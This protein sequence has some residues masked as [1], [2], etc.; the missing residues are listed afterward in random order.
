VQS[1]PIELRGGINSYLYVGASPLSQF[2]PLG[3]VTTDGRIAPGTANTIIC[4]G[5]GNIISQVAPLD[6]VNQECLGD[7]ILQHEESHR[8]DA[9]RQNAQVC[10]G[11][12]RG[13]YVL[14][15]NTAEQKAGEIKAS[16]IEIMCLRN[17]ISPT[18]CNSCD[19]II[20]DRIKQMERYRD[21]F[22]K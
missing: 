10:I 21:R 20:L 14:F 17:K 22:R 19:E 1:D 4:N 11:K 5:N 2:D 16:E 15:S 8:Q 9:I 18:S 7:C 3:L 6:P 13:T 12:P